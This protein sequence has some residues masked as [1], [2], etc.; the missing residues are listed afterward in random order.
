MRNLG[1][2]LGCIIALSAM[3]M[4]VTSAHPQPVIL[5]EHGGDIPDWYDADCC[6]LQDCRPVADNEVDFGLNSLGQPIVIHKPTG[7]EFT[8]DRWRIS[9]DERFHV[10]YRGTSVYTGFCVYLRG[11]A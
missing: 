1:L 11:G 2:W 4:L 9:K 7:L 8:K 5:H 6:N 3:V 10:C